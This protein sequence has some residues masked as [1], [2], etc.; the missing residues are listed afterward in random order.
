MYRI[1]YRSAL[2]PGPLRSVRMSVN[3][4]S[5]PN[6]LQVLHCDGA[7]MRPLL[8]P[9]ATLSLKAW[10]NSVRNQHSIQAIVLSDQI[11]RSPR[12]CAGGGLPCFHACFSLQIRELPP[13]GIDP[14][15]RLPQRG[16]SLTMWAKFATNFWPITVSAFWM[17]VYISTLVS[18]LAWLYSRFEL[19]S[20][21]I[22]SPHAAPTYSKTSAGLGTM[23]IWA[24]LAGVALVLALT[25]FIFGGA[26]FWKEVGNVIGGTTGTHD[27]LLVVKTLAAM[28]FVT[29]MWLYLGS[30]TRPLR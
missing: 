3:L 24:G 9:P 27:S 18:V 11:R 12:H 21:R 29:G 23:L 15:V 1:M 8:R 20:Y 26:N 7:I 10:R 22:T 28:V 4:P 30:E 5:R 13:S 17:L 25:F 14:I 16:G 19:A 2:A 6:V